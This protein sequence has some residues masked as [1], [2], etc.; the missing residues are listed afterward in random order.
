MTVNEVKKK[1]SKKAIIFKTGAVLMTV[2]KQFSL[3]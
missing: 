3:C 1:F 2:I